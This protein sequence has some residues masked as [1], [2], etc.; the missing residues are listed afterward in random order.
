MDKVKN[1]EKRKKYHFEEPHSLLYFHIPYRN[2]LLEP[3]DL[4]DRVCVNKGQLRGLLPE[5]F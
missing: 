1:R 4:K 2:V 3:A 5:T